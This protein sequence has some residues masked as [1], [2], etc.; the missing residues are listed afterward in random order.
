MISAKL[1]EEIDRGRLGLNQGISM[2]LPKFESIVDGVSRE[3]Y[4]LIL[5]NSG[6]GKSSFA[7]YAY[8]YKPL[9]EHLEDDDY[10]VLFFA[11]EMSEWSLY[12]K[13]LSI[14]IFETYGIQLSFKEI[15]SK[16]KEYILS[17]EHYELV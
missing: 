14:Y 4:T 10:K 2:G 1:I 12:I 5:S 6:A 3:T 9:M 15:L 17:D 16:K 11:L 13:L 7:L 8:V